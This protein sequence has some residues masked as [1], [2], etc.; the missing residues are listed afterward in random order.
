MARRAGEL[1]HEFRDRPFRTR[2]AIHA[3]TTPR[4]LRAGD[5]IAPVRGVRVPNRGALPPA[6]RA[7]ARNVGGSLR[8]GSPPDLETLC[9]AVLLHRPERIAFSHQ[10][11]ARIIGAPL[12]MGIDESRIHV[13]VPAG[14]RALQV[15]AVAGHTLTAWRIVI[16][17]GLP[18]TAPEQ[19]WLDLAA[20]LDRDALVALGD[21]LVNN[22]PASNP[23]ASGLHPA[24][25][26]E[27]L[28]RAL[29]EARGRRGVARARS[30]LPLLRAG[31]ESPAE[32]RL[33][34]TLMDG[35]LPEPW[36]NY[37]LHDRRGGFVARVD[38]AYPAERIAIEYEGEHHRVDRSTWHR[39]IHRRE[40]VEDL[41]W[42]MVRVTAHDLRNPH[43]L[44]TRIRRLVFG[45]PAGGE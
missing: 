20:V 39:D 19:I 33:R 27:S 3:G 10:T 34:L 1:T 7:D 36:I 30:A 45:G 16:V 9:R 12:P 4:R 21:W 6:G 5:L 26:I 37:S 40:A 13:S 25:T 11:A 31:A 35:G 14:D 18:I 43:T 38:L 24:A 15:R 8:H 42:R 22:R 32:S 17:R 44:L 41:G 28:T 29:A 23:P 2:D